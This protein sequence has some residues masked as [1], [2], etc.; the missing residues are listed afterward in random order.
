M[1]LTPG[2]MNYRIKKRDTL[3]SGRSWYGGPGWAVENE[4]RG[5]FTEM[6]GLC[7]ARL[8]KMTVKRPDR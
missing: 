8:G 2:R 6:F 1:S 3:M 5:L 4:A 7:K